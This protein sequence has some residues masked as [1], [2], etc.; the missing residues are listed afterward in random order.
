MIS[1]EKSEVLQGTLLPE[2]TLNELIASRAMH[3]DHYA[4]KRLPFACLEAEGLLQRMVEL[5]GDNTGHLYDVLDASGGYASACLGAGHAVVKRAVVEAIEHS[6]YVTDEV[7]SLERSLLLAKLFGKSGLWSEQFPGSEY[8]VSGRNSGSEG[9]ELALRL[10]LEHNFDLRTLAPKAGREQRRTILAFEGAWHGWTAGLLPLLN[11]RHFRVGLPDVLAQGPQGVK[12]EFLPF[13]EA[14]L[15]EQF[16]AQ[17]GDTLA[18]VFVEPVQGDAGI[19]VP[20]PHYLRRLAELCQQHG[21]LLVADEVMT[22]AKTGTFFAMT[23]EE[24]PIPTDITVIGK[25]LGMGVVSTS[26]V[27]ARRM[28]SARSS[29]AVS[30]S[31]LRPLTCALIRAGL[32]Y[33]LEEDLLAASRAR[34]EELREL[35][36]SEVVPHF[37]QVYREVRGRG[38]LNGIEVTEQAAPAIGALR[39]HLIEHGVYVE[40]MAGAGRRSKGLRYIF[41]T[42]RVAPPLIASSEDIKRIVAAIRAGTTAFVAK[43]AIR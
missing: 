27:I 14:D 11:R 5:S 1:S 36:Q 20:P 43:E 9:M 3:M 15:L 22:F 19:L 6:G 25:S 10:V 2:E 35:L 7:H 42:M 26:L 18:A 37:P 8:H 4:G 33:I 40:F 39:T 23:D 34:G 38:L 17:Q 13:A 31:D 28:L 32:E 12:V 21:V 16:F 24:G 30:T 41:P 29:G